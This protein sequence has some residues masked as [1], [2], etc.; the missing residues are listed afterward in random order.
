M[1]KTTL[2]AAALVTAMGCAGTAGA[3]TLVIGGGAAK[4]CA[5]AAINGRK[6]G[7]SVTTCTVALETET[8]N[9]RDRARTYVNRGVLQMRQQDYDGAVADFDAASRIDPNLGE[10]FVNRG[11]AYVGTSRYGE[12]LSQID[13]GLALGVKDPEKAYYNRA[14]ANEGLGDVTAAYRD[15]SKA[16]ELAPTW[17]APKTELT[18]FTVKRP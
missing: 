3:S 7:A 10:A 2:W 15:F 17:D 9:F 18:R 12:G 5:D 6:D 16:A 13:Q 1:L 11:A 8:L 4:D 14:V